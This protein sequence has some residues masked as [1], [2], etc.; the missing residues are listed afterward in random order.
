MKKIWIFLLVLI[1]NG[2]SKVAIVNEREREAIH[3]TIS[4]MVEKPATYELAQG[5]TLDDL[6]ELALPLEN[7]DLST[8]SASMPLYEGDVIEI[9]EK[10]CTCISIN[11]ASQEEL[12]RITGVGEKTAQAIMNYRNEYGQFKRV[13]ELMN[14]KGIGEKKLAKMRSEICL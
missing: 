4:G 11:T 13:E 3:V 9:K 5:S 14:I 7:A 12:M 10:G 1:L 6:L 8:L 2:C